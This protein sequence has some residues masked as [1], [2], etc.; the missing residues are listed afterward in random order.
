MSVSTSPFCAATVRLDATGSGVLDG[1][2]LGVKDVFDIAGHVTG[3]GSPDWQRTHA[4]AEH[5]AAA[6]AALLA[7]GAQMT[8]I[9]VTDEMTYSLNGE[10]WHYG[11]PPNPR[12][13]GRIPGGSSSGSVSAVASDL[14]D[15][16]LGTDCGG[17]VRLPASYCGVYGMRPSHGRVTTAGLAPLAQSFDTVGWFASS[18]DHLKRVGTVLLGDD[19]APQPPQRLV[20]ASDLFAQLGEAERSALAPALARLC[21][22]FSEVVDV[23]VANEHQDELMLA[24][25]ILQGAEIWAAHGAWITRE[26]PQ[27]GPG[28]AERFQ[29]AAKIRE[30]DTAPAQRVRDAFRLRL[31]TILTPGT[32]LCLPSAPGVAP[33]LNTPGDQLEVFRSKA[34]RMLCIA[35]MSGAPQVSVPATTLEGL[36][37]GLSLMMAPGADQALL[38]FVLAHEVRDAGPGQPEINRPEVLAEV[39]AVFARYEHA[40]VHNEVAVLDHLFLDSAHTLRYGVAEN[41]YGYAQI[42][43]FRAGRPS[44]GLM[45]D[46][47]NTVITTYGRDSATACTEFTRANSS[48]IGRQTQTWIRTDCGWKVVAAHVSL[49]DAPPPK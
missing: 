22:Q 33:E 38:D 31:A 7:A 14:I 18:A 24:F 12:A 41:L 48:R 39:Q 5:N 26:Q 9:T 29:G 47:H 42:R 8:G 23:H 11:T 17:S 20:I 37:L 28:I 30:S 1:L 16:G 6:V 15:I 35:G 45:R 36:P 21:A 32:M 44:V 2:R 13:P 3:F 10:N 43:A 25:R 19:A 49:M 46:L 27:F 4:A 40:L 34:M